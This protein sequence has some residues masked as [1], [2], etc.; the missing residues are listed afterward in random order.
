[1]KSSISEL[2]IPPLP[3][4]RGG[5]FFV[6]QRICPRG[7]RVSYEVLSSI[8]SEGS[9]EQTVMSRQLDVNSDLYTVSFTP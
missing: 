7:G 8:Q 6:K 9:Y 1:M 2:K 5:E 4:P 3:G